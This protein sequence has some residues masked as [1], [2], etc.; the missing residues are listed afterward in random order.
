M[1]STSF[2]CEMFV[3]VGCFLDFFWFSL[4]R[5]LFS[6]SCLLLSRTF[7]SSGCY[8]LELQLFTSVPL[9]FSFSL[10]S[11]SIVSPLSSPFFCVFQ[12]FSTSMLPAWLYKKLPLWCTVY[13]FSS[14]PV[15]HSSLVSLLFVLLAPPHL[16]LSQLSDPS[17]YQPQI[18]L[19]SP[20]PPSIS[21]SLGELCAYSLHSFF[22]SH[23]LS[24]FFFSRPHSSLLTCIL[25]HPYIPIFNYS[26]LS[27]F[28]YTLI[29]QSS[30]YAYL[31]S[32]LSSFL[33]SQ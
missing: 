18:I 11:P 6:W 21:T 17:L 9:C 7:L 19:I 20:R 15:T 3:A 4:F 26:Y 8:N 16:P 22:F 24:P 25:H 30:P 14:S 29:P 12:S 5:F 2:F 1:L 28:F 31:Q 10:V 33:L 13:L 32:Y 23:S 27:F